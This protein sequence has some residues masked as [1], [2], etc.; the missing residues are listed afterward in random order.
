MKTIQIPSPS[1]GGPPPKT[2]VDFGDDLYICF[3]EAGTFT[4]D[5]NGAY[6][7]PPLAQITV[8]AWELRGPYTAPSNK[9]D[10]T[11]T[12]APTSG[13]NKSG[14]IE[15]KKDAQCRD[16]TQVPCA[17]TQA[18]VHPS[19]QLLMKTIQIPGSRGEDHDDH[20]GYGCKVDLH[21]TED[22]VFWRSPAGDDFT[23]PIFQGY[24]PAD[25]DYRSTSPQEDLLLRWRFIDSGGKETSGHIYV[26]YGAGCSDATAE[27]QTPKA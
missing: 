11:W 26:E 23:P 10:V 13:P 15:V 4:P 14:T 16:T 21:F 25:S 24:V 5:S 22:G 18:V 27:N 9:M 12:F 6:F 19:Q 17:P 3:D 2:C 1:G 8:N 20:V 7:S